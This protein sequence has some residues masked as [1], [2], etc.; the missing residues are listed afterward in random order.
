MSRCGRDNLGSNPSVGILGHIAAS[1]Q[2]VCTMSD[3]CVAKEQLS[4]VGH[5]AA[6]MSTAPAN[7]LIFFFCARLHEQDFFLSC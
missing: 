3:T 2:H 7:Q 5:T 4:P 6:K 1:G